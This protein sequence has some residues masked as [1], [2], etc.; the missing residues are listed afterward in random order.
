[1]NYQYINYI[2]KR[3]STQVKIRKIICNSYSV[4]E[5]F[6]KLWKK[7]IFKVNSKYEDDDYD[8]ACIKTEFHKLNK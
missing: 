5:I 1:M 7:N 8:F 6:W 4:E 3:I 2:N